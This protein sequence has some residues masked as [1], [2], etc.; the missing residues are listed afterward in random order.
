MCEGGAE[1]RGEI[2]DLAKV[3]HGDIFG[4]ALNG[5]ILVKNFALSVIF[6]Y[7]WLGVRKRVMSK[8]RERHSYFLKYIS[9]CEEA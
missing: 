5:Y 9:Q 1:E 6:S 7:T 8:K 2:N 3:P 4:K